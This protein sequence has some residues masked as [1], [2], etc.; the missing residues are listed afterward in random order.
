DGDTPKNFLV[1]GQASVGNDMHPDMH[2]FMLKWDDGNV[3]SPGFAHTHVVGF[4]QRTSDY[5]PPTYPMGR[6]AVLQVISIETIPPKQTRTYSGWLKQV[7]GGCSV[8]F[9]GKVS[10]TEL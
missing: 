1:L 10:A 2:Q 7:R 8:Y 9:G 6:P 5:S 3:S 4:D